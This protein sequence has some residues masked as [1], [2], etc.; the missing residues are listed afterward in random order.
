[1]EKSIQKGLGLNLFRLIVIPVVLLSAFSIFTLYRIISN[2][3][4]RS[5]DA[6]FLL[7]EERIRDTI[8]FPIERM[9]ETIKVHE[10]LWDE[11][12]SF[13]DYLG[14]VID[15]NPLFL[16][17]YILDQQ[18]IVIHSP[19]GQEAVL[20]NDYSNFP[21]YKDFNSKE[22]IYWSSTFF[23][24][25]FS[26]ITFAFS[27][28][29]EAG[30]YY[31]GL[32]SLQSLQNLIAEIS[33]EKGEE[34]SVINQSRY[35]LAQTN[36]ERVK[37]RINANQLDLSTNRQIAMEDGRLKIYRIKYMEDLGFYL[38]RSA[39]FR[40]NYSSLLSVTLSNL[41]ML[42]MVT[43]LV[44]IFLYTQ[45]K[46]IT[47]HIKELVEGSEEISRGHYQFLIKDSLYSE[48]NLL[49][50]NYNRMAKQIRL[51]MEDKGRQIQ[52]V[53]ESEAQLQLLMDFSYDG[54]VFISPDKSILRLSKSA[55]KLFKIDEE[56][57]SY[58]GKPCYDLIFEKNTPCEDCF[59][60]RCFSTKSTQFRTLNLKEKTLEETAIPVLGKADEVQG[61]IMTFRDITEKHQL[62][63]ELLRAK[64]MESLG[65]FAG[66]IAHDFNNILQVIFS[67]TELMS[68]PDSDINKEEYLS[69]I[70]STAEKAEDLV[71]QLMAFCR[72]EEKSKEPMLLDQKI[73][74]SLS[75]LK[76]LLG[77]NYTLGV[78]LHCPGKTILAVESNMEQVLMNLIVNARDAMQG[79]GT[80]TVRTGESQ[81]DGKEYIYLEVIDQG[82]GIPESMKD[83]IFEPFFTTKELGKGTG[84]GLATVF[85]IVE[86][87]E[88]ILEIDSEEGIGSTFRIF[89]PEYRV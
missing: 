54:I 10:L 77:D 13:D 89:F 46:R 75:M 57:D 53:K 83:K 68:Q 36:P 37:Q 39:D 74:K 8:Q 48:L 76:R 69:N 1:M 82:S 80:I 22:D 6:L 42:G 61:M 81:R 45:S 51:A 47:L 72:L 27:L 86:S 49:A 41:L 12:I 17:I 28:R 30:Q 55:K 5:Q 60:N 58:L 26:E 38:V 85:G 9:Q 35:Y 52:K 3:L 7:M 11:E 20:G 66:G 70:I 87:H 31:V 59:L 67:Y 32:Y 25:E 65:R 2:Q 33:M 43:A 62:E 15:N 88:G 64:K 24:T 40:R 79:T 4:N 16:T 18:G 21:F 63:Q 50:R 34:I 84:L 71:R 44:G 23:S 14:I 73:K 29:S 56:S 78:E 19:K